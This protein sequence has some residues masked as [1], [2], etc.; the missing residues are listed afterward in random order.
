MRGI[1][2][3]AR[4]VELVGAVIALGHSLDLLVIAEGVESLAHFKVLREYGCDLMQ[5][6]HFSRPLPWDEL[7]AFHESRPG[8]IVG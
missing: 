5:G 4:D 3:S 8:R 6:F 2:R 1:D 7:L